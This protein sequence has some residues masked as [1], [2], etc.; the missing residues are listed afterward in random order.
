MHAAASV[1]CL[2]SLIS[3]LGKLTQI[4]MIEWMIVASSYGCLWLTAS[5]GGGFCVRGT[6]HLAFLVG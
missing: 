6:W 5:V 3:E 4:L 1:S 2:H